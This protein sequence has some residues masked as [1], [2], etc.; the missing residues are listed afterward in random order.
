MPVFPTKWGL[1]TSTGEKKILFKSLY[2]FSFSSFY[3][4]CAALFQAE[5]ETNVPKYCKEGY[6]FGISDPAGSRMYW[7][8]YKKKK[9]RRKKPVLL[10]YA[11]WFWDERFGKYGKVS[12]VPI[13][14]KIPSSLWTTVIRRETAGRRKVLRA[15]QAHLTA[16]TPASSHHILIPL[17]QAADTQK[18]SIST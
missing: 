16:V 18:V 5:E 13:L 7:N 2:L 4:H 10:K 12:H 8:S 11:A 15:V 3:V 6:S 17:P 1:N 14:L 9:R